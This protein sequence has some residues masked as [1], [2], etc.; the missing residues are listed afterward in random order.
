VN[1]KFVR[2]VA[3]LSAFS[4]A[5]SAQQNRIAG[6]IDR[7]RTVA[8]KASVHP[9]ARPQ[10]DAGPIDPSNMLIPLTLMLG[11]SD[12]QQA[13]LDQ[14]LAEQQ[15]PSSPGYH[16]WLSPDQF[17]D[18]FGSSRDDIAEIVSWLQSE[19]LTV[20]EI[21]H[22]RNWIRF[23]GGAGQIQTA[24]RT[25]IRRYLVDG[26]LHFAN[27]SEPSI[28]V[29][30]EPI[31]TGIL[32]LDDFRPSASALNSKR[33][34]YTSSGN[35]HYLAP[36]DFATIY[37]LKPLYDAGYDGSGQR[38]VVAGQSAIDIA[39]I[40]TFRSSLGLPKNDPQLILVPGSGDPGKNSDQGE[41]DLDVEW[42]GAVARKASVVYVYSTN[43]LNSVIYAVDQNLAPI[44]TYSFGACEPQLPV[45]Y[46]KT[47]QALAQQANAQGITW[48][49]SSG[50]S[51]AASCD[52]AFA[53]PQA[54]RGLAVSFPASLPEIT[55][56]GGTQFDET[57]G[58]YWATLN[59]STLASALSYIPEAAWNESG[60]SGLAAGGGGLSVMFPKPLW[61]SAAGVPSADARAVPDLSLSAAR[62][63]GYLGTSEQQVYVFAGTSAAAPA[64]AGILAL[65]NQYLISSGIQ[66]QPGQGN[67]NPNLYALAPST[68]AVFHDVT[69][70]SNTVSC[71]AETKDCSSGSFGYVAGAGYDPV[72]GLGSVDGSNL[73]YKL[74]ARWRSPTI[75]SLNPTSVIAGSGDFT[76]AVNGTGFGSGSAVLWMGTALPTT[77]LGTTQLLATVT[78]SLTA[79]SGTI[80]IT[81]VSGSQSSNAVSLEIRASSGAVFNKQR[82]TTLAPG[83]GCID[84][85]AAS[86]FSTTDGT[87]YLYFTA[88][89]TPG[90]SLTYDWIAPTGSVL[91]G[92]G[93]GWGQTFGTTCLTGAKLAV[94][95]IPISP[96]GSWQARVFNKGSLLF[97]VPFTINAPSPVIT[98]V[99]TA[100]AGTTIAQNTWIEIKGLNLVMPNIPS[101]DVSWSNAPEFTAGRMPTQVGG[102]SVKINGKPAYVWFYCSAATSAVCTTDQINVLSPFDDKL[103]SVTVVVTNGPVSSVPFTVDK[104]SI[105]PSLLLFS[106]KGYVV[107]THTNG[108]LLGPLTLYPGSS[109]PARPLETVILWAIGFG[110]PSA[111]LVDGSATQIA[112]MPVLPNC[113]IGATGASVSTAL[114]VS[115][116]LFALFVTIPA[117]AASGDS[118]VSC[119]YQNSTTPSGDL[120]TIQR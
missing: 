28:P 2:S 56:V 63:D 51:G 70:G 112:S 23:G 50:D 59:S 46:M 90:D 109:T 7:L 67:I 84:P 48:V 62:H 1:C 66:T 43:V 117:D 3:L 111:A 33:P 65:V 57:G 10:F 60:A 98:S 12:E 94:K 21:S 32:G 88:T 24:L 4:G 92:F 37:N 85:P 89:L 35:N 5:L 120:I 45:S 116:G 13:A 61:Q 26:E 78:G 22:A 54:S 71:A 49:A 80:A 41:G 38:I 106:P 91:P 83:F 73:A 114:M 52:K 76:L 11:R 40:Q 64:F 87:V 72:T 115:P 77:V 29:A 14:L 8:L 47:V 53:N 108:S 44:I 101:S 19:G 104:Q 42:A 25:E 36:D 68:F 18:R 27:A 20:E 102:V 82:T 69:T 34:L 93:G 31:V 113:Q 96:V 6:T 16:N 105:V 79:S 110:I 30:V 39:D 97:S 86:A 103:G 99:K 100:G 95:D 15:N 118:P 9:S 55:G 58:S 81:V 17:A 74:A 75:A 107:A 119:T